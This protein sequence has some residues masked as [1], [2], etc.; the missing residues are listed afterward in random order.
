MAYFGVDYITQSFQKMSQVDYVIFN[1][2]ATRSANLLA[3]N[4]Y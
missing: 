4:K 2:Y 1:I 3:W